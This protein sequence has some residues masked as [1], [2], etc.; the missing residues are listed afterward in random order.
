[1]VLRLPHASASGVNKQLPFP[2]DCLTQQVQ[3]LLELNNVGD[4]FTNPN[5]ITLPTAATSLAAGSFQIQQVMFNNMGDALARRV[6]LSSK[7][8]AFPCEFVQQKVAID[9]SAS[10]NPQ[11]VVLSGFRAGQVKSLNVWL[12]NKDDTI[13]SP[14]LRAGAP[15]QPLKWY[16]PVSVEMLYAGDIYARYNNG[17][18]QLFNLINSNKSPAFDTVSINVAG[19]AIVNPPS[20]HFSQWLELPFAQPLCDEDAHFILLHGKTITNG[21]INLNNLVVP[22]GSNAGW[23]LNVSYVYNC[24]ILF[25]Q[26]SC[27]Y[28]F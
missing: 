18:G 17:V 10:Q 13:V 3:I 22:A 26:G 5:N 9:L 20:P 15:Y 24:T 19:G 28:V 16:A 1:V 21:I 7:A 25:S 27:D 23:T 14:S 11:T 6:D 4:V 8:Y 12:T 2:T